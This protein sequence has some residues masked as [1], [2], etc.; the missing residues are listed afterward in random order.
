MNALRCIGL[1]LLCLGAGVAA[2]QTLPLAHSSPRVAQAH[3]GASLKKAPTKAASTKAKKPVASKSKGRKQ[4]DAIAAN[5]PKPKLDLTLPKAMVNT[6]EPAKKADA[7][8]D[9]SLLPSYFNQKKSDDFQL[10]GRLLSNEMQLPLRTDS[11]REVDGAA[12]DFQ[13]RQ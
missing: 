7:P 3:A 6:L 2:A 10:N 9:K 4:V 11:N 8:A 13:F 1:L 12:L 5:V